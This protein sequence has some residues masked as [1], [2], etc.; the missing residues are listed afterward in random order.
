MKFS[1]TAD[2][3][4]NLTHYTHDSDAAAIIGMDIFDLCSS[5]TIK[6]RSDVQ[7]C[8]LDFYSIVHVIEGS[9]WHWTQA[10]ARN[11]VASGDMVLLYP[12]TTFDFAAA[13]GNATVDRI[14]FSGPATERLKQDKLLHEGVRA[15]GLARR[16]LPIIRHAQ[17]RTR[18]GALRAR[19]ALLHLFTELEIERLNATSNPSRIAALIDAIQQHPETWRDSQQM[20][21]FCHL[22]EAQLRRVFKQETGL[23]PK[24]FQDTVRAQKAEE[25]LKS[26]FSV[27]V[28]SDLLGFSDPF[29]F[30]RRFKA[31]IGKTPRDCLNGS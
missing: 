26:G 16:L 11:T 21:A 27:T 14:C 8:S 15:I 9:A 18:E 3:R 20:A 23:S 7:P 30:S 25:L 6:A 13:S 10:N 5:H 1:S 4:D 29:H 12:D 31:I 22:S 28:V 17:D 19:S 2:T 24:M